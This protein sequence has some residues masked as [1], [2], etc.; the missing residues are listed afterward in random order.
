MTQ[1]VDQTSQEASVVKV[2]PEE[3]LRKMAQ[4]LEHEKEARKR[5]EEELMSLKRATQSVQKVVEDEDES[6]DEPYVDEKRL[7]K[8]L[9]KQEQ[10]YEKMID[11]IAERKARSLLE[12]QKQHEFLRANPDFHD[13]LS[14]EMIQKLAI[15][16]PEIAEP[17]AEM[18]E[19]FSRNK[20]LYQNIKA[21]GLHKK[22]EPKQSIQQT[23]EQNRRSPYYQPSGVGTAPYAAAGDFSQTGQ[24]NAYQKLQELKNRLR[25]G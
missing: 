17:L 21:L 13:I 20:L 15:K 7:N 12:Q 4:R 23:I 18:P 19:G 22:E 9:A 10:K 2:S 24:K 5:L 11:E 1:E 8:K 6:S 14:P 16:H 3:N 25:L